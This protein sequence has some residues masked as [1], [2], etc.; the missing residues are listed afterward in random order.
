[1]SAIGILYIT[2]DIWGLFKSDVRKEIGILMTYIGLVKEGSKSICTLVE[3][4]VC[5]QI[6]SLDVELSRIILTNDLFLNYAS[7]KS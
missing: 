4:E 6:P 5:K 3:I 2:T 1:M 7:I